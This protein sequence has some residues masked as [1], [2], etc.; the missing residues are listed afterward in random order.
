MKWLKKGKYEI[1]QKQTHDKK[2][3]EQ[4]VTIKENCTANNLE[5]KQVA[6]ELEKNETIQQTE[7]EE[8]NWK[9]NEK[10]Q[11]DVGLTDKREKEY[12]IRAL[13]KSK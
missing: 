12:T 6:L 5:K 2:E 11:R 3:K 7:N 10:K 4:K 9:E 8:Q 13:Q 1:S